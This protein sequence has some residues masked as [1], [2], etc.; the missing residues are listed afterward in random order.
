MQDYHAIQMTGSA[1]Q[2]R[3]CAAASG[4]MAVY[5]GTRGH[6]EM[7]AD[8]FR[9]ASGVSCIPGKDT[10]SG[11]LTIFA[12]ESVC[13][14]K[15]VDIEYGRASSSY[16]RRWNMTEI[17]A[18]LGTYYGAVLL[19]MYSSVP[20]PWRAH[21][22]TFKGGHSTWVHDYRADLPDSSTHTVQPTFCW[23]DP[24]RARPIRVPDSV[25]LHY[26]QND[27]ALRGFAGFV[28]VPAI[29]GGVY[30]SPMTDRTRVRYA[31]AAV[32][33]DRT[34]GAK[35]TIRVI[36][37]RGKLVEVAMYM[38]GE[39]YGTGVNRTKWGALSLLGN[40]WVHLNRLTYTGGTT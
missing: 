22:S 37:P 29:P 31:S 9:H 27:S 40:E 39:P 6:A 34:T 38:D 33:S 26:T 28:K 1:C 15:G 16:Y 25:V 13:A 32:H 23:H 19:G 7:D 21:G 35:S 14:S 36:K 17:R 8:D 18:R 3:N 10:P 5:F 11:G 2:G 30:A 24:L 12:V 4:A 20:A